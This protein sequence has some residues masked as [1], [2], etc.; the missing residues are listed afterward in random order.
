MNETLVPGTVSRQ[1]TALR[2]LWLSALVIV[3]DQ[4]TKALIV[5]RMELFERHAWLPML[6][7]TRL[8]NRGA[9]FSFLS[10]ASGWQKYFFVG[11]A[12]A[13]SVG[14]VVWL[15]RLA[16][17]RTA[18]IGAGLALILGGAVGNV[19]DRVARGYVVDFIHVHWYEQWYFPAFNA[20]DSAITIGAVL[21][22]LDS[23]LESRKA[24]PSGSGSTPPP[25]DPGT[26]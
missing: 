10:D 2:W 3:I 9:A 6:E 17:A 15:S 21:L 26:T 11:L 23:L 8:H 19:I 4:F 16:L 24:R 12:L 22:V 13:V 18:L 25:A 7:I 1:P 20:A 5:A 14:I